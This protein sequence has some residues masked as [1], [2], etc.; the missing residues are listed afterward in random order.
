MDDDAKI[1]ISGA[2]IAGLTSAIWLGRAGYRPLIVEKAP[3]IRADGYI[4][5]LSHYAYHLLDQMGILEDLKRLNIRVGHSSYHDRSGRS[6]LDLDYERLFEAGNIVQVMRDDLQTVLYEHTKDLA[7][8]RFSNGVVEVEET[9]DGARVAFEDGS[10][11]TF[12]LVIGADG[13]HSAVRDCV[14]APQEYRRHYLGLHSA[15]FRCP[16][17]LGIK[18]EYH[19]YL[20]PYRHTI[21]YTT[22]SNDIACIFI[23][24]N[25]E[26]E[27][28]PPGGSRL[29]HLRE[30]YDDAAP[31]LIE[32]I[33]SREPEDRVY[34]EAL[35]QIEMR[36]WHKGH[37]VIVGDGAHS[38]TQLSGQGA[39]MAI[40]GASTL[41]QAVLAGSISEAFEHYDAAIRPTVSKL[42]HA[43]RKNAKWY[44]PGGL[45]NY[46]VRDLSFRCLPREFWVRYFKSKYSHG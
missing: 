36:R 17:L 24:K 5:S 23:W 43:V 42:Q 13:L 33:D 14:F 31:C 9:D 21:V 32:L 38:L 30:A 39:S 34:M 29:D 11:D 18:H 4:I 46:Y 28:P 25:D 37:V 20:E 27:V 8:F 26:H 45:L 2:G 10:A 41:A 22:R 6:V 7:E 40:R 16:N 44:V 12:D 19:A 35:N 1:L 3:R 15:A